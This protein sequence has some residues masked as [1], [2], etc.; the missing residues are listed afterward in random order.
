MTESNKMITSPLSNLDDVFKSVTVTVE[1]LTLNGVL[2]TYR[3]SDGFI[4]ATLICKAANKKLFHYMQ[5]LKENNFSLLDRISKRLGDPIISLIDKRTGRGYHTYVHPYVA[6]D[7]ACWASE[8]FKIDVIEYAY[9]VLAYKT[10][11]AQLDYIKTQITAEKEQMQLEFLEEREKSQEK[12]RNL[13]IC[14]ISLQT[15]HRALLKKRKHFK[16]QE[17]H[18]FYLIQDPRVSADR[19]KFGITSNI[20]NRLKQ[21]RTNCPNLQIRYLVFVS[22]EKHCETLEYG[23]REYYERHNKL[24]TVNHEHIR[25]VSIDKVIARVEFLL[26]ANLYKHKIDNTIEKY[27]EQNK[28][29]YDSDDDNNTVMTTPSEYRRQISLQNDD[30]LSEV[31][32]VL[33]KNDVAK[34]DDLECFNVTDSETDTKSVDITVDNVSDD[35]EI[36]DKLELNNLQ[37]ISEDLTKDLTKDLTQ[38]IIENSNSSNNNKTIIEV[39][40]DRRLSIKG[41]EPAFERVIVNGNEYFIEY[42]SE[43]EIIYPEQC[44]S[45]LYLA[46]LEIEK[47]RNKNRDTSETD[48]VEYIVDVI[49]SINEVV[50]ENINENVNN[51][52][53][54][55]SQDVIE[56]INESNSISENNNESINEVENNSIEN[57]QDTTQNT[58]QERKKQIS[59]RII[60]D[61]VTKFACSECDK[62]FSTTQGLYRHHNV[63]H[64]NKKVACTYKNCDATFSRRETMLEHI[65]AIHETEKLTYKCTYENCSLQFNSSFGLRNHVSNK[66][67]NKKHQ[68]TQC[69]KSFSQAVTLRQHVSNV[70]N[71]IKYQCTLCTKS[72]TKQETL[73]LHTAAIHTKTSKIVCECSKHFTTKQHLNT[74]K[75]TCNFIKI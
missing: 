56:S 59:K 42:D 53:E 26:N 33:D 44:T 13:E 62:V 4:N 27:N 12:I 21:H 69:E 46:I 61:G 51:N 29:E 30:N 22:D 8:D 60:V 25:G 45:A 68:C 10:Y 49:E 58:T 32:T 14:N 55:N 3:Q 47:E 48:S 5:K 16:F 7:I 35:L 15:K 24:D 20:N 70:H 18:C 65:K 67:T 50:N 41:K 73:K 28:E 11:S 64:K 72:F 36:K 1:G 52:I 57:S 54:N 75:K 74:H 38:N 39:N 19:C 43:G 31:E 17:G 37:G 63:K 66:H 40:K 9:K 6:I 71:K 23:V 34:I 2:I